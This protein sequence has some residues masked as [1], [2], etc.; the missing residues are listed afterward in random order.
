M[1]APLKP[2]RQQTDEALPNARLRLR[3]EHRK[4]EVDRVGV[5][6]E[7]SRLEMSRRGISGGEVALGVA[8]DLSR[9]RGQERS[10]GRG[11]RG[12]ELRA[13]HSRRRDREDKNV[14]DDLRHTASLLQVPAK[15][16]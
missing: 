14:C 1:R 16:L 8:A 13:E 12:I 5:A 2:R 7:S 9:E 10:G 15:P 6:R 11:A 4:D 3:G